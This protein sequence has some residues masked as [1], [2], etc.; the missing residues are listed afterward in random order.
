MKKLLVLGATGFIGGQISL[1]ALEKGWE[2]FGLRRDDSRVGALAETPVHWILGNLEDVHSLQSAMVGMDVVIHAAGFYPKDGNY[3]KVPQQV[4]YA[5][6][7]IKNVITAALQ[8]GI[9]QIIYTSSLTTI[10][11]P[12]LGENRLADERDFYI[13]GSLARSGYYE[14]K[15]A[16]EELFLDAC[17]QGFPGVVLNPT[18]VFGPGDVY[19]GMGGLL[20]GVARG[21]VVGWLPGDINVVDVRDVAAAHIAAIDHGE[22]GERYIIGGHNYSVREALNLTARVAGV[23]P[24]RFEIPIWILQALVSLG[25]WMPVLPLPSNHLRA[26][27]LWQG[28]DTSKSSTSFGISPRPFEITVEETLAWFRENGYF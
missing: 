22:P 1:V 14:A 6:E 16:M 25:D 17:S 9:E 12:P 24:P 5:K 2:V 11:H 8:S 3:R 13:P 20:I 10:G 23:K 21:A 4:F 7:E 26:I 27:H 28:Y 18:A 19:L 15:I